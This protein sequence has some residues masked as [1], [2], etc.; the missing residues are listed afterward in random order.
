MI[1]M[2]DISEQEEEEVLWETIVLLFIMWKIM[3]EC[4]TKIFINI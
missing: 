4:F 1:Q 3:E 2:S